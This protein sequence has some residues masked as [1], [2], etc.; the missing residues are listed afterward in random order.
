[1]LTLSKN[2][3]VAQPLSAFLPL[4]RWAEFISKL[5]DSLSNQLRTRSSRKRRPI[6]QAAGEEVRR[7]LCKIV[8]ARHCALQAYTDTACKPNQSRHRYVHVSSQEQ[9]AC[10]AR[11][12]Q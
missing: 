6:R 1:M 11:F 3:T 2:L 10:S 7:P 4:C 8:I 9:R 5:I 12:E